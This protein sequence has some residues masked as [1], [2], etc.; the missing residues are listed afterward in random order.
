M[1]FLSRFYQQFTSKVK[2]AKSIFSYI[3]ILPILLTISKG[4]YQCPNNLFRF[5]YLPYT[6]IIL[7]GVYFPQNAQ[8]QILKKDPSFWLSH[9]GGREHSF[10]EKKFLSRPIFQNELKKVW[11]NGH[12][13]WFLRKM[14]I[15]ETKSPSQPDRSRK[16]KIEGGKHP[17]KFYVVFKNIYMLGSICNPWGCVVKI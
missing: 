10:F 4:N 16:S 14:A 7:L 1:I 5:C 2:Y 11:K 12:F 13:W 3:I 8:N 6:S 17:L 15:F 9:C